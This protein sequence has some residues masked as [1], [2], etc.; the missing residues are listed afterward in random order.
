[1]FEVPDGDFIRSFGLIVFYCLLDLWC[2][3][4]YCGCL[5]VLCVLS[6]T[7]LM[8]CLLNVCVR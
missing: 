4:C 3:E 8:N 5:F 1:M 7:V 6:F 2:G